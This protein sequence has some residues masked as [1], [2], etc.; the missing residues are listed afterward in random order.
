VRP[1]VTTS[2]G[3]LVGTGLT[4]RRGGR[5]ILDDVSLQAA[6]GELLAVTGPSGSGKST[7]L[8]LLAGILRPDSGFVSLPDGATTSLVLQSH[9]LVAVLTTAENVELALQLRG[10]PGPEIERRAMLALERVGLT[11][12]ADRLV[13]ELSGGQQQRVGVARA[14]VVRPDVL[15]A[16]EPTAELDAVSRDLVLGVLREEVERGAVVVLATHDPEA[17][18]SADRDVVLADGRVVER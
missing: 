8:S 11:G 12:T 3:S 2:E 14:L 13:E 15:L 5:T 7:L 4:I 9:G 17:A 6:R 16:D 18:S 10:V 1:T